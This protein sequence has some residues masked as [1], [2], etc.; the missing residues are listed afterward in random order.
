MVP[1]IT[2]ANVG[3]H[4]PPLTPKNEAHYQSA[5]LAPHHHNHHTHPLSPS[6]SPH[7][8]LQPL[9]MSEAGHLVETSG[10]MEDKMDLTN[11]ACSEF[12]FIAERSCPPP[13]R[14]SLSSTTSS[15]KL[16]LSETPTHLPSRDM[17][18]SPVPSSCSCSCHSTPVRSSVPIQSPSPSMSLIE[19]YQQRPAMLQQSLR[20]SSASRLLSDDRHHYKLWVDKGQMQRQQHSLA[21][22]A[23][24]PV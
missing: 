11:Y 12:S 3:I 2:T 9:T 23:G 14:N 8:L 20:V 16:H 1:H 5:R 17:V 18:L 7:A 24:S 4:L 22:A 19:A 6:P 15:Q 13:R 10:S 21:Y